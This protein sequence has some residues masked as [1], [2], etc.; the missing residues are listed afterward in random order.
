MRRA[1]PIAALIGFLLFS[2]ALPVR[3]G[4]TAILPLNDAID[5]LFDFKKYDRLQDK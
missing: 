4:V 5:P 2:A 1:L 3:T